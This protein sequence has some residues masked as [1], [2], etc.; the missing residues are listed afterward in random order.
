MA[1]SNSNESN[2]RGIPSFWQN[3]TV[4]PPIPWEEWSDLFQLAIIAKENIDIE[5]LLDPSERYHPLPPT[6]ENPP[7]N[8]SDAQK[9]SRIE[10]NIREQKRFDDEEMAS[11]KSETKKFNGMRLEEAD[12]KLRSI[13]Y[14]ALGNE[15]KK[16]FGQKF[17]RV[18][19]LQISFKEF[20]ENLSVA[21]VRKINITF[22]RH[23]LLNRK[24]R[25][26]ESLEQFWGALAEMAKRCNIPTGEDEWIRDIFINNMK[27]SDIQR[28]LL[29]ETLP[30][31]E[32]LNVALIDE[33]GITNHIKMTSTFKSNGY[34]SN[35]SFNHFNVKR[36]PTLNIERTNTCMKCGG[37]FT[38]GHLAVCP[39]KDKTCTTCKYR[40]NFTRLCKS[41]RKNV[42][43]V[44]SQ[45]VNNTDHNYPSEQ[46]D[47]HIDHANRECCGVINAWSESGQSDNN[48][49]SVLN[50]T[51]IYDDQGK[52]LKK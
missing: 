49:Y 23:K 25:D 43:I 51:T 16:I 37:N 22:E 19:V 3:H 48:D 42:N 6:L 41:R 33:K 14:L 52:E 50:V 4:D 46:P 11:I 34:S 17:T 31:L 27:N 12:K 2:V 28:K 47:V 13:L 45:I 9:T 8:E 36:E 7:E 5:N 30:P 32:A 35:K 26:R 1:Q 20:W 21:F 24:Q 39:A 44:D 40:G 38:K 15:G 29:T 10:R 18:K